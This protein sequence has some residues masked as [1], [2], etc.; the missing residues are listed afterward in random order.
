MCVDGS[1]HPLDEETAAALREQLGDALTG[2]REYVYTSGERRA[3]GKYVVAR[4]GAESA[5]N[6]KVFES[7]AALA[8][9]YERLPAQFT[10]EDIA[11]PGLTDGRRHLV[12]RHF[13]EHPAFDC[14]LTRR[15]P[16]TVRKL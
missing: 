7:F 12:L 3:D 4:R 8:Q 2:T 5:G 15:Q 1:T 16:L 6:R 13:V 10:A 14:E 9:L 11:E